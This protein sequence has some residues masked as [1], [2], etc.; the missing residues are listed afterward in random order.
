VTALSERLLILALAWGAFAFGA[1][2]SWAY[3]PLAIV[4]AG[5][6]VHAL[7][8]TRGWR[9]QRIRTLAIAFAAVAAAMVVQL[10][11]LPYSVV[12]KLSPALDHFFREYALFYHPASLHSLSLS[13]TST[14]VVLALFAALSLLFFGLLSGLG[15]VSLEWLMN[16]ILGLGLALAIV[17]VV[18]KA[19]PMDINKPL[20][21]GFW[22][23]RF[24]GTPFGPFIN[25]NHF[26]GW[27]V[28]ALPLVA[29]YSFAVLVQ[30]LHVREH[31]T[32]ALLRW[33]TTVDASRFLHVAFCALLMGMSL[34]LTGSRSGI[35]S[36]GVA[37]TVFVVLAIRHFRSRRA[38]AMVGGYLGV[39]LL[40]AIIWAGTDQTVGRFLLARTDSSGGGRVAAWQDTL[41]IVSDFP[42]FGTGMGTYGHPRRGA[43]GCRPGAGARR[44]QAAPDFGHG[45]RDDGV[46]P[47][48]RGGR[49]R[50][51]RR[52][53]ARR[54]QPADARQRL[55][56]RR[57]AGHRAA[58]EPREGFV[59]RAARERTPCVSR[60]ISTACSPTSTPP[61][62]RPPS[63]CF[64]SSTPRRS[65]RRTWRRRRRSTGPPARRS[66]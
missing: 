30:T 43:R 21:Y 63:G 4:I 54:V 37:M 15:N 17:G 50:R 42:L 47:G 48:R 61:S 38:R 26:A 7:V 8:R 2:Y 19:F 59:A 62:P 58:P 57:A 9:D 23:P 32:S 22:E 51:H 13:W 49:P 60:L 18:Q 56:L 1:V 28:M 12:L 31:T 41:R 33:L 46:G 52:A 5:I 44:H 3:W 65:R 6:G 14:L 53:V 10:I 66:S 64:P 27:M 39:L 34:V 24:S 20:V 35:A 45:R 55:A 11:A 16:Q 40:G 29:G 36:F 25:R